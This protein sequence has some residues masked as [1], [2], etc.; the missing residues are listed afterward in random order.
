MQQ[1]IIPLFST[2]LMIS[3]ETYPMEQKLYDHIMN[4][5]KED[6]TG[7]GGN[8]I[9]AD[10]NVLDN[11]EFVN[12]RSFI[13]KYIGYYV[14]DVMRIN[15]KNEIYITQSWINYNQTNQAHHVHSHPNSIISGVFYIEGENS[16]IEFHRGDKLLDLNLTHDEWNLWNS[17]QW[18]ADLVKNKLFLFPSKLIHGVAPNVSD[19]LRVSLSFNTF[20]R[21]EIGSI[22]QKTWAKI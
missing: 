21:G 2:P 8:L 6:N 5:P 16:P 1:E 17:S 7:G 20:V 11:P 3:E 12:L 22:K 9:T 14:R 19:K 4:M 15:E 13:E 18:N 10:S